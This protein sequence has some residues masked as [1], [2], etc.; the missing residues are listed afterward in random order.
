MAISA[1]LNLFM[2]VIEIIFATSIS[3]LRGFNYCSFNVDY[4]DRIS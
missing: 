1:D 4:D 3:T 2:R